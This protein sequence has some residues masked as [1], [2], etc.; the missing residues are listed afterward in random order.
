MY[1]EEYI[2]NYTDN[3]FSFLVEEKGFR[4]LKGIYLEEGFEL[5]YVSVE[6]RIRL[7]SYRRDICVYISKKNDESN[8]ANL[9]A[10]LEFIN[11]KTSKIQE[12]KYYRTERDLHKNARLQL[13]WISKAISENFDAI[14]SF[15]ILEDIDDNIKKLREFIIRKNPD[16]FRKLNDK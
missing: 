10:I 14:Y 12:A 7:Q 1:E 8:E 13:E 15:F 2:D 16:L 9:F 6:L 11:E 5:D 3:L 4:K